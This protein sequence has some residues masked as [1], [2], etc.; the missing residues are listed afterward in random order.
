VTSDDGRKVSGVSGR[1]EIGDQGIEE[2]YADGAGSSSFKL[3]KSDRS[4]SVLLALTVVV[5]LGCATYAVGVTNRPI[6]ASIV[7]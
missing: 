1:T 2:N 6:P 4:A 5:G 3:I 7:V